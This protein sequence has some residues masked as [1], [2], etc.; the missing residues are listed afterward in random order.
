MPDFGIINYLRYKGV[1]DMKDKKYILLLI[2]ITFFLASCEIM[3]E[4]DL[5][6]DTFTRDDVLCSENELLENEQV[7]HSY[8]LNRVWIGNTWDFVSSR[9][10]S[11]IYS[12]HYPFWF[13]IT[14][15]S[16]DIVTGL[17]STSLNISELTPNTQPYS[18][19]RE[20]Q[21]FSGI[22]DGNIIEFSFVDDSENYQQ[23]KLFLQ[24]DNRIIVRME[25]ESADYYFRP[26]QLSDK[27]GDEL[28]LFDDGYKLIEGEHPIEDALLLPIFVELWGDVYVIAGR[29]ESS[30]TALLVVY[31]IDEHGHVV[32]SFTSLPHGYGVYITNI[33]VEDITGDGREDIQI[34]IDGL[35]TTT[36]FVIYY[37]LEEGGFR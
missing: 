4:E 11:M 15:V 18:R 24:E 30:R 20:H 26:L 5:S 37:Q 22:L 1:F 9:S 10:E 28:L 21:P 3:T 6:N 32:Y 27:Y 12:E 13:I 36:P 34:F 31:I 14:E 25:N 8:L 16:A 2:I 29:A 33:I 7:D 35:P 17:W 19:V 23:V